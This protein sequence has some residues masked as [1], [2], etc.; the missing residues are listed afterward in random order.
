[1]SNKSIS[2]YA[3]ALKR[4]E[5]DSKK[6]I[7]QG[8]KPGNPETQGS[9]DPE[10]H[11]DS[12]IAIQKPIQ[13]SK[14]HSQLPAKHTEVK[15]AKK[16]EVNLAGVMESVRKAV[17]ETG[18]ERTDVAFTKGEKDALREIAFG[19]TLQGKN[20]SINDIVRIAVNWLLQDH[21]TR[22]K[23]SILSKTLDRIQG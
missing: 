1:M 13:L 5:E 12:S 2:V 21:E 17:L 15:Q 10:A 4:Q 14:E 8:Q 23:R 9:G 20:T 16:K 19:R 7:N 11:T 22:K 3:D 18:K 6:T